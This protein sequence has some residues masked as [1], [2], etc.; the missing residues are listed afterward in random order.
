MVDVE[1]TFNSGKRHRKVE[2]SRRPRHRQ[3]KGGVN[4][5]VSLVQRPRGREGGGGSTVL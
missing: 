2:Q 4:G 5:I 3:G 1:A